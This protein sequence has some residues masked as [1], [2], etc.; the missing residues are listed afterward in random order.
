MPCWLVVV[1]LT[2]CNASS[3][4]PVAIF[5]WIN[6]G[7][8]ALN[9]PPNCWEAELWNHNEKI[10]STFNEMSAEGMLTP[11]MGVK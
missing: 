2:D 3:N 11:V 6:I 5:P 7:T 10:C 1:T 9:K 8:V 4:V